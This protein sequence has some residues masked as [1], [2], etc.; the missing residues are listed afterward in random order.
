[1]DYTG[2][3]EHELRSL[4]HIFA[5]RERDHVRYEWQKYAKNN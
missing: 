5:E 2:V 3:D 4:R 1:M